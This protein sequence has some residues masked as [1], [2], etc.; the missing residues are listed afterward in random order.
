MP[1]YQFNSITEAEINF[2]KLY[3]VSRCSFLYM[4]WYPSV[5]IHG[6]KRNVSLDKARL[7]KGT[8]TRDPGCLKSIQK[9]PRVYGTESPKN[10]EGYSSESL[11]LRM[12]EV[13][14]SSD[15][16]L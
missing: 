16:F 2:I 6:E 11:R 12:C 3:I 1:F 5:R 9:C 4:Q 13:L 8:R 10:I 14:R 15:M 7:W